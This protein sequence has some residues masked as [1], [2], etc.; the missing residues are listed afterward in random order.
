MRIGPNRVGPFGPAAAVRRRDQA[1]LQGDHRP[2]GREPLPVLHRADA[3]A[4]HRRSPRGP[5]CR[6]PTRSCWPNINAGLLYIL[7][8]TSIGVYG[9]HPRRLG[10]ELEVRVPGRLRSAAQIVSLR[11]RDGLRAGRR[12]DGANSLNLR[13]IV[14]GQDGGAAHW[15]VWPLFPLFVVYLV[16]GHRRDQPPSVRRGRRRVARS[17]PASTSSTRASRSRVFF[18]AEYMNMIL[19]AALTA[20]M[21][22]G[23]W[24]APWPLLNDV[25][26]SAASRR[27]ATACSGSALK[28]CVRPAD[29]PVDPR[30]VPALPLRPDHAARLEGVHPGHAGLDHLPRRDDAD[31]LGA[32]VPLTEPPCSLASREF[33]DTWFLLGARARAWR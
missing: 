32:P 7:A 17:S 24:L 15:Y 4:R 13:E 19:I 6:S 5:S 8:M 14:L 1:A 12:A 28:M 27:S 16:S 25:R 33:F 9:D 10:V 26:A 29:L 30:D 21:F 20:I 31:A 22:L 18:L 3:V 2:V 23:G 11:D